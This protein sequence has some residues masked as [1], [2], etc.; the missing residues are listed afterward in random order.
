[1]QIRKFT[2]QH[3]FD[4]GIRG[5]LTGIFAGLFAG[6]SRR[7]TTISGILAG[8]FGIW[9]QRAATRYSKCWKMIQNSWKIRG[10]VANL[11]TN[12]RNNQLK[13]T[14]GFGLSVVDKS[15]L[16]GS[17]LARVALSR[18]HFFQGRSPSPMTFGFIL[19]AWPRGPLPWRRCH[20]SLSPL[21][22]R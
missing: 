15:L 7:S 19:V 22:N 17:Y 12:P 1:M 3:N 13:G 20:I 14:C 8:Y 16:I 21:R 18:S 5:Y 10:I 4:T 2:I 6:F 11:W 9:Q